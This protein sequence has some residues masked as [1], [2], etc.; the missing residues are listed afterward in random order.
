[1]DNSTDQAYR[2]LKI[3]HDPNNLTWAQSADS[4]GQKLLSA[5][6]WKPGQGLGSSG[7]KNFNSP[8]PA[9]MVS[10]KDDNLG[11]GASLKSAK[12]EQSRTGLDAFQSLL[13]RLNS[14]DE[15][16]A[17][18]LEQRSEGRKLAMWT[19]GKWGGV[20]FVPGGLLVQGDKHRKADDEKSPPAIA[21]K[22]SW[23]GSDQNSARKAARALRK[24]ERRERREAKLKNETEGNSTGSE[25]K[26]GPRTDMNLDYVKNMTR[27]KDRAGALP[28]DDSDTRNATR[29]AQRLKG[30]AHK[31]QYSEQLNSASLWVAPPAEEKTA[32]V[33][34]QLPTPPSECQDTPIP[35][36]ALQSNSRNGMHLI[37]GRNIQ[38]KRMAFADDKMLDEVG[39]TMLHAEGRIA[40]DD[41]SS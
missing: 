30:K 39:L 21:A 25:F 37:R 23:G 34:V 38:A 13:G 41:R 31:E 40:D 2:R 20:M 33:A 29:T 12:P 10:Y 9:I 7:A 1:M 17:K 3:S 24:A 28:I 27:G 11:L 32:V 15:A 22:D 5:Q 26:G 14:K 6:G 19:Q 35:L 36:R 16:E 8:I 18:R 4:Y